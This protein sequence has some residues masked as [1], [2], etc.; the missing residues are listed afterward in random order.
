MEKRIVGG[1][2]VIG[3]PRRDRVREAGGCIVSRESR[4]KREGKVRLIYRSL[5]RLA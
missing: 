4:H 3:G 1:L 5:V 2:E